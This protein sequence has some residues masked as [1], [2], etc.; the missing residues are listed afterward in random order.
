[1]HM[2][3]SRF[4]LKPRVP[5]MARSPGL[6]GRFFVNVNGKQR[7]KTSGYYG[8]IQRRSHG[9]LPGGSQEGPGGRTQSPESPRG[10]SGPRGRQTKIVKQISPI[11]F[12]AGC[13]KVRPDRWFCLKSCSRSRLFSA[14]N[15]FYQMKL[16]PGSG[17]GC[18]WQA[19]NAPNI[20]F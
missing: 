17:L 4:E 1:M 19:A 18:M 10:D 7:F 9:R 2:G 12:S 20:S 6:P 15:G 5:S 8:Q 13:R 11:I 16:T 3:N 14:S